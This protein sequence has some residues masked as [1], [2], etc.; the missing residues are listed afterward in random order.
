MRCPPEVAEIVLRI[1]ESG[2]LRIRAAAWCGQP[3]RCAIE[4]DHIH[5][6]PDLLADYAREKLEYYW[7]VERS[8]YATLTPEPQ[9]A[10]W[11]T[12]WDRLRP[13]VEHV[14]ASFHDL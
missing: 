10:G 5:N 6:L 1:L 7:D 9:L 12:L 13:H 8:T 14:N 3:D 2:L 4:A 11:E